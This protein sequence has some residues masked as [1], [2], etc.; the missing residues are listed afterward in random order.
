[1][2]DEWCHFLEVSPE[3]VSAE[4][5]RAAQK[6]WNSQRAL[7]LDKLSARWT[8]EKKT[9]PA[10]RKS[11]VRGIET[12]TLGCMAMWERGRGRSCREPGERGQVANATNTPSTMDGLGP[13]GQPTFPPI[14]PVISFGSHICPRGRYA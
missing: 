13:I 1:M 5:W 12:F 9:S 14:T 2:V 6:R 10:E 3:G 4:L 11:K 7:K 8:G